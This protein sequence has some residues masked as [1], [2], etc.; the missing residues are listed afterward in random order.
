MNGGLCSTCATQPLWHADLIRYLKKNKRV[1]THR[2]ESKSTTCARLKSS[3]PPEMSFS[4]KTHRG[5]VSFD[6]GAPV[7][8]KREEGRGAT[9]NHNPPQPPWPVCAQSHQCR[10]PPTAATCYLLSANILGRPALTARA[11]GGQLQL[12][13]RFSLNDEQKQK[14]AAIGFRRRMRKLS[15]LWR[16]LFFLRVWKKTKERE[17]Q[18]SVLMVGLDV[19]QGELSCWNTQFWPGWGQCTCRREHVGCG[20]PD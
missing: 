16:N 15:I 8:P 1:Q 4:V 14:G 17:K 18:K 20:W 9:T 19:D 7:L 2:V 13:P 3:P 5:P 10:K 11:A 6:R 12:T